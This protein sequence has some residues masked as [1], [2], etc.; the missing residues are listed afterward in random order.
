M[1]YANGEM[2]TKLNAA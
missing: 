1:N 2:N